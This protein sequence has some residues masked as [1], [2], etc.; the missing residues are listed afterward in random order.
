MRHSRLIHIEASLV[1]AFAGCASTPS[2]TENAAR[3]RMLAL[4]MPGKIEIVAPFTR[5]KS[6]DDD[7]MPDGIE[8]LLQ[9]VNSLDDPGMIV[10]SV[11]VD[12]FE[13]VPA[14]SDP[15]GRRLEYWDIEL[16][17]LQQ[18]RTFWNQATQM[19]EFRLEIDPSVIPAKD[20][21]VVHVTYTSP[22]G[23]HLTDSCII[24]SRAARRASKA[25]RR[26]RP[27]RVRAGR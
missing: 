2:P 23:E 12:L 25:A 20:R 15:K 7:P 9:A 14:S 18:Q 11:H 24:D 8:L 17:T 27:A 16:S 13:H 4:L 22:L 3:E 1:L 21:F 26:S 5:V 6:F 19:Y 10:G